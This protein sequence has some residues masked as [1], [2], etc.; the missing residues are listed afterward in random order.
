MTVD[1]SQF[2]QVFFEEV[3]EHLSAME[4]LLLGI[5]V[6]APS[7]DDL[8]AVF[9]AAHSIK[10]GAGTFGFNDMTSVTHVLETLLDKLRKEELVLRN[11]M[12]DVFLQ[13]GDVLKAQME[14]HQ[15]GGDVDENIVTDVCRKLEEL[16]ASN[17]APAK[18]KKENKKNKAL[19]VAATKTEVCRQIEF[20]PDAGAALDNLFVELA[21]LGKLEIIESGADKVPPLWRLKLTAAATESELSDTFAFFV[22]PEKLHIQLFADAL[23]ED[24]GYGFFVDIESPKVEEDPGYGFF[25]DIETPQAEVDPGYGF[26]T[27]IE[28]PQAQPEPA[29]FERSP[30]RRASDNPILENVK[31]GRR[32]NDKVAVNSQADA[33]TIRVNTDKVDLLINLVGELVITQAMLAQTAGKLDPVLHEHLLNGMGQLERNTRDL[34]ESIMSIRMMPIGFVFSRFPRVVRDLANKLNKQI[35]LKTVGEG[36]ELDKG[37]IEKLSDPLTHLVRNSI[38]HGIESPDLR[39]AAGK[40]AKGTITL[41]AFHQGSN[42]IIEVKDNGAGLNRAKILGKA[43]ERGLPVNDGMTDQEVWQ[44]IFAPG[45]STADVVTDVSGRGVGMDVVKRNIQEMGGQV[46]ISS[47]SGFGT[48]IAI[49]LPLTLAILDGMSI[50]VGGQIFIIPLTFISESLQPST[51]EI[52]TVSGQGTVVQVRGA[53]LPLVA[54]HKVFGIATDIT[55]PER[56]ILVLLEADGKKVALFVDELVGQHQVVLKSLEA[57]YRKVPYVSGATIM[58]DGRVAMI[59]DVA[60]LVRLNQEQGMHLRCA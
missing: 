58:G 14:A 33:S 54:L 8:N 5:D 15:N 29:A 49:R 17:P 3:A 12:I 23:P 39:V 48:T 25:T 40:D 41:R 52:R 26:F 55:E 45:F 42:I 7:I 28:T 1:M 59:L 10:G 32:D 43:K 46:E 34:Q 47:E 21:N 38:D 36:T 4:S 27:D 50:S 37:L 57:N 9:R 16:S 6:S 22:Q 18:P 31:T 20:T 30:G 13:A 24:E 60:S 2:Y 35:E 44:L 56:G 11:E 19:A 53:Y 51:K